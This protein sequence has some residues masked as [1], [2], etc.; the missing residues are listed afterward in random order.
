MAELTIR[1]RQ[2][3]IKADYERSSC[4]IRW[5]SHG[6]LEDELRDEVIGHIHALNGVFKFDPDLRYDVVVTWV[7][8]DKEPGRID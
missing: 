2:V 8:E 3:P 6:E 7:E 4:S 5:L 1:I